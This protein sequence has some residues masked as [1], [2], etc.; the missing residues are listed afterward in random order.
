MSSLL[1]SS[2]AKAFPPDHERNWLNNCPQAY[3]PVFHG[4]YFDDIFILFKS[5][6]YLKHFQDFL[7]PYHINF[8]FSMEREKEDKLSILDVE[9]TL[10]QV[11]LQLQFIKNLLLVAYIVTLKVF[12]LRFID[13]V[14]YISQFIDVFPFA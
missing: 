2:L 9:N 13:L 10:E 7:N 11:N 14:W 8:S 12:Y 1:G 6:D 5:N 3:E 4:S